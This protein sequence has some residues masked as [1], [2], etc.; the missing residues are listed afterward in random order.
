MFALLDAARLIN[1]ANFITRMDA[2]VAF[3]FIFGVLLKA[4]VLLYAGARGA[5]FLFKADTSRFVFPLA[6]LI[7]SLSLLV[8]RNYAEHVSEGLIH[9]MY[10]L[11]LPLQFA[12]PLA[13]LLLLWIRKP[14]GALQ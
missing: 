4:A 7:G 11:H 10:W 1:V 13:T 8:S 2:L 12:V 14:R 6:L 3:I 5:A 9:A